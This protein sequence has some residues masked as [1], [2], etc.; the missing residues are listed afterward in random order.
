ME[1][2]REIVPGANKV[3]WLTDLND[4]KAPQPAPTGLGVPT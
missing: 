4:P 1:L 2:A 3:G